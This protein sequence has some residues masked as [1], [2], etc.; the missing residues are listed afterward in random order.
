[1]C[2]LLV[3]IKKLWIHGAYHVIKNITNF[4][5]VM[6]NEHRHNFLPS[7][8]RSHSL[9]MELLNLDAISVAREQHVVAPIEVRCVTVIIAIFKA[10]SLHRVDCVLLSCYVGVMPFTSYVLKYIL[11]HNF[12]TCHDWENMSSVSKVDLSMVCRS[13]ADSPKVPLT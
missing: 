9:C 4:I 5:S 8:V 2:I 7:G 13:L 10:L 6:F 11:D 1:M 12:Q 3:F